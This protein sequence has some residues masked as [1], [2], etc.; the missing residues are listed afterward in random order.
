MIVDREK[1]RRS[2]EGLDC[3]EALR[4]LLERELGYDYE[5][6]RIPA[7]GLPAGT[8]EELAAERGPEELEANARAQELDEMA[9]YVD[10]AEA[11]AMID[12]ALMDPASEVGADERGGM[13][14][15]RQMS[16]STVHAYENEHAA[17]ALA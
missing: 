3:E 16:E 15:S 6:G 13:Q 10:A 4:R 2:L 7:D 5:G 8:E 14:I 11:V 9:A 12:L 17:S 1:V